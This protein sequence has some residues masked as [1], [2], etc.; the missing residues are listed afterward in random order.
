VNTINSHLVHVKVIA[1]SILGD[2]IGGSVPIV[3]DGGSTVSDL[4][5]KLDEEYGTAYSKN[6]AE[7]LKD[8]IMKRFNLVVNGKVIRPQQDFDTPL[9]DGDEILFFHFAAGG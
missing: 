8:S 3:L 9:N 1:V 6:T 2:V 5:N 4:I 7:N